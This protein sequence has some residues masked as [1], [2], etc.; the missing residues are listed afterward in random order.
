MQKILILWAVL[1]LLWIPVRAQ[2][3]AEQ[4][5]DLIGADRL[6]DGLTG[7][8]AELMEGYD[9]N[10]QT[11]FTGGV[12]EILSDAVR[13]STTAVGAAMK[14]MLRILAILTLCQL[15]RSMG[16]E[17]SGKLAAV[18]AALGITVCCASDVHTMVGLGRVTVEEICTYTNLLLPVMS[19]AT[20][21]SGAPSGAGAIYGIAVFFCG[22]LL[23]VCQYVLIPMIYAYLALATADDVLEQDRLAKVREMLG[24]IIKVFLK[25]VVYA[26]T[27]FLSITGLLSG[28][29]DAAV[30]KTLKSAISN[31]VPLVGGIISGAADTVLTGA[32]LIRSAAGTFGMLA[33]LAYFLLPF[34][35]IGIS[36]LMF[37]LTAALGGLLDG[38]H[39]RLLDA[40]TGAMGY[41]L[42]MTGSAVLMGLLA[43]CFFLKTVTP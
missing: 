20:A 1:L 27:G 14:T 2:D 3:T 11:D 35:R 39:G 12:R 6:E 40:V 15:I 17:G 25:T 4:Q 9:P 8:A 24:W 38:G 13:Q 42:A 31:M 19:A 32:G 37:K 36:Y 16:K 29:A 41:L 43:C 22:L 21:A 23:Q 7:H 10:I 28:A 26:F 33:L 34:L 5:R 30:L 18:T